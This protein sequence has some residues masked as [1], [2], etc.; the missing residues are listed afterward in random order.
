M[1]RA[2]GPLTFGGI[3]FGKCMIVT[4]GLSVN[5]VP[6]QRPS[7]PVEPRPALLVAVEGSPLHSVVGRSAEPERAPSASP[8]ARFAPAARIGRFFRGARLPDV[9]DLRAVDPSSDE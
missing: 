1:R 5:V 2:P 7:F 3:V 9:D 8:S 6:G 4:P